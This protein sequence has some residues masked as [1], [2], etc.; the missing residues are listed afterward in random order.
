M[1]NMLACETLADIAHLAFPLPDIPGIWTEEDDE[2]LMGKCKEK[3]MK[4]MDE[5]H[6]DD[7]VSMRHD[8][9]TALRAVKERIKAMRESGKTRQ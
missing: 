3:G 6:G 9:L 1:L 7:F 5:K 4:E 8:F 2:L